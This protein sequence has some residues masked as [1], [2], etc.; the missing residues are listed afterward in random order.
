M[1]HIYR[2]TYDSE[3][4]VFHG[5]DWIKPSEVRLVT[6]QLPGGPYTHAEPAQEGWYAFGGTFLF[7]SNG[8]HPEFNRPIPLHDRD[9]SLETRCTE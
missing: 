5:R 7:T 1:I 2:S 8:V 6:R 4:N 3:I 9:M